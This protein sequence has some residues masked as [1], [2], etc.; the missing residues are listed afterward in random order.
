LPFLVEERRRL[1]HEKTR[2]SNRIAAHL[3]MY[4]PQVLHWFDVGSTMAADFLQRWPS[5]EQLQRAKPITIECFFLDHNSR[6]RERIAQRLEQIRKAVPTTLDAEVLTTCS[7]AIGAWAELLKQVLTAI[8]LYE[9]KIDELARVHPDYAVMNS[10]RGSGSALAPRLIAAMGSQRER[11]QTAQEIQCYSGIAPVVAS[12]SH[13]R[14]VHWRWACP[15]FLS[16]VCAPFH[17]LL[18]VGPE[19]ITNSSG[20]KRNG[21]TRRSVRWRSNKFA[22]YFAAGRS[23]SLMTRRSTNVRSMPAARRR[24]SPLQLSN[25]SRKTLLAS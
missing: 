17:R 1:V 14:R 12:S 25:F 20:P 24:N 19:N 15:K 13:Q 4:F 2:Y 5:L 11:Y 18:P 6:D 7:T 21:T 23:A 3:K 9:E 16:R 8:A 22:S 10:F